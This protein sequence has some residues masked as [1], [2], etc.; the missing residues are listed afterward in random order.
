[1]YF[2]G[3][4]GHFEWYVYEF[5]SGFGWSGRD[6]MVFSMVRW[7]WSQKK[8]GGSATPGTVQG[9]ERVACF[10]HE[11]D[12]G[13]WLLDSGW[14]DAMGDWLDVVENDGNGWMV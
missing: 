11:A 14:Y 6:S 12:K 5:T 10:G 2:P 3:V 9:L 1:M 7:W 4:V 13:R 8:R